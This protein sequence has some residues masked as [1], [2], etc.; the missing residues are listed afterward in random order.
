MDAALVHRTWEALSAGD[1]SALEAA[2]APEARW[3][4]VDETEGG[5]ESRK[6]ILAVMRH[7]VDN[8]LSGRVEEVMDLGDRAIVAFRPGAGREPPW[9]LDRGIRYLVLSE[10]DGLIV[11]MKGCIDRSAALAY[12]GAEQ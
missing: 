7:N 11:E 12:A 8:G 3:L 9:P 6:Q 2:F 5:C 4:P 1:E 10:R